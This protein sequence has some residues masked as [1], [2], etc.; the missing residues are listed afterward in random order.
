MDF[1][2]L[3]R[4]KIVCRC[5]MTH[6]CPIR[7][8]IIE[9]NAIS[10]LS[11]LLDGYQNVVLVAD[12][13]TYA[14][15][16]DRTEAQIGARLENKVVYSGEGFLIPDE[17][18][19]AALNA[20]VSGKTDLMVGI[21]SGVIND[22]CKYIGSQRGLPYYIVATAPS[23]DGYASVGAALVIGGMK[24]NRPTGTA[25]AIIAD[26]EVLRNAPLEMIQSGYGDIIGKYSCL[27]DW[28]FARLVRGEAFCPWV[29]DFIQE[30]VQH[31]AGL[32]KK[33]LKRD[34]ES[35]KT[36]MEAL[37]CTGIAMSYIGNSRPASGSEHHL[38]HFFEITGILD[39]KPYF[40]HGRNVAYSTVITQRL[41]EELLTL[42][43]PV[44]RS[45]DRDKWE[46]EIHR[47]Y[48]TAAR[49]VIDLQRKA[50]WYE[51]DWQSLYT[52]KWAEIQELF[53]G[54]PSSVSLE[55]LLN[56]VGLSMDEFIRE[57]GEAKIRDAA[58]YAKDLKN[59]YTVLWLYWSLIGEDGRFS[60]DSG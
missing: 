46:R 11:G 49:N 31:V 32:G 3:L 43:N 54:M 17:S 9:K 47:L 51:L 19:I 12:E 30:T 41:R 1:S 14:V 15:C 16:G 59:R 28:K 18:S 33:L 35:I 37:V 50:G 42:D 56:T 8:V 27:N 29:H 60:S 39:K 22:L 34:G 21:G 53:A 10:K 45:F 48:T 23:M 55:H 52:D 6:Y 2:R 20:A 44:C 26:T 5:G 57:Y 38:S 36:L 7:H 25:E 13:N 58:V 4:R 40:L 24:V